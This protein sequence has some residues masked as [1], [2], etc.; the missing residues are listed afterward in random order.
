MLFVGKHKN[1]NILCMQR[2]STIK[3]MS[4]L[5]L[6]AYFEN[7]FCGIVLETELNWSIILIPT[8]NPMRYPVCE[9]SWVKILT[10]LVT[11]RLHILNLMGVNVNCNL[12]LNR[13]CQ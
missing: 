9:Y 3:K 1:T 5:R 4:W 10:K 13:E 12:T 11:K 6:K 7:G 8:L 2:N